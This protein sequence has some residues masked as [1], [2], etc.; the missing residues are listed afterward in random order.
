MTYNVPSAPA[1]PQGSS[2]TFR[3]LIISFFRPLT[4][5]DVVPPEERARDWHE[6]M[7]EFNRDAAEQSRRDTHQFLVEQGAVPDDS[8]ITPKDRR[9]GSFPSCEKH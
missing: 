2:M 6:M 3:N 9:K 1:S 4:F 5:D 8:P 7:R